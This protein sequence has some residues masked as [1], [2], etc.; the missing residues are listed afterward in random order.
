MTTHFSGG[1]MCGAVLTNARPIRLL[2]PVALMTRVGI[3]PKQ[4]ST[5]P[6][7]PRDFDARGFRVRQHDLRDYP[8][9]LAGYYVEP[10]EPSRDR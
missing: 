8:S 6:A 4:T 5:Q 10:Q 2:W 1:S 9:W 3:G 7:Q